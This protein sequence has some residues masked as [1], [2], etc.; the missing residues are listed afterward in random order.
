MAGDTDF[1]SLRDSLIRP[2]TFL[3]YCPENPYSN[4]NLK[5]VRFVTNVSV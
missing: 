5:I 4:K 2:I 3:D 1:E